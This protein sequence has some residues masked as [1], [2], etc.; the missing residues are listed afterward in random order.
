MATTMI[1]LLFFSS[2]VY[3]FTLGF[4]TRPTLRH[5]EYLPGK[6]VSCCSPKH[7]GHI[8][9][10]KNDTHDYVVSQARVMALMSSSHI[11]GKEKSIVY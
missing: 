8:I 3:G 11:P 5:S 6:D 7:V 2:Y 9:I 10:R 1:K 4:Y